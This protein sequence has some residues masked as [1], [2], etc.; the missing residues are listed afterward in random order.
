[1]KGFLCVIKYLKNYQVF[2]HVLLKYKSVDIP[3]A[4][5]FYLTKQIISLN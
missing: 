1:M 3:Q 4:I 5:H 2:L